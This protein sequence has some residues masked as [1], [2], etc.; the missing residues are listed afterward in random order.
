[1][2]GRKRIHHIAEIRRAAGAPGTEFR[3][4]TAAQDAMLFRPGRYRELRRR[5]CSRVRFSLAADAWRVE[6]I[7]SL[8]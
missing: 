3:V 1:M 7:G 5:T 2:Y 4:G 6:T 8:R